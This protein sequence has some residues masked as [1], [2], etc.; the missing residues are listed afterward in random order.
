MANLKKVNDCA[1]ERDDAEH[2]FITATTLQEH[3]SAMLS[4]G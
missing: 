2:G 3:S 1:L 4:D